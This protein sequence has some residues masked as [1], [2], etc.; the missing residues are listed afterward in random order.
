MS[1]LGQLLYQ[2]AIL[3][4]EDNDYEN[5][6]LGFISAYNEGESREEILQILYNCFITPNEK[7]FEKT[8]K[9]N[10]KKY[11][12]VS[13]EQL[14]LDF[15]PVAENIYYIFDKEERVFKGKIDCDREHICK[16]EEI[17]D[18]FNDYL[19]GDIW[20]L[21]EILPFSLAN[22]QQTSV[23]ISSDIRKTASFGKL[24]Q[25]SENYMNNIMIFTCQKEFELYYREKAE[26]YVPK[27]LIAEESVENLQKTLLDLHSYRISHM[28][29]N[30][31]NVFLSVCIPSLD[32]GQKALEAVSILL[33]SI[34]DAEIEVIVSNNGS[35]IN[36][37]GYKSIQK[38]K[39]SRL[40]YHEFSKNQ[41]FLG[42]I[43]KVLSMAR[44]RF[45]VLCSDEDRILLENLPYYLDVL[46][47]N[48]DIGMMTSRFWNYDSTWKNDDKEI[49]NYISVEEY[50][51]GGMFCAMT[52]NYITGTIYNTDI[53]RQEKILNKVW[54]CRENLFVQI[55]PHLF[56]NMLMTC[57]HD[58]V[59]SNIKLWHCGKSDDVIEEGYN[60][61]FHTTSVFD[62]ENNRI[63]QYKAQLDLIGSQMQLSVQ[64]LIGTYLEIS[65]NTL[66]L[67]NVSYVYFDN[68]YK[69]KGYSHESLL[70][71][72][73]DICLN[74]IMG[75]V[76][77]LIAQEGKD[78]I[79]N[80]MKE[81][82]QSYIDAVDTMVIA[83]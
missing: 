18:R 12:N 1:D 67:A 53:M 33:E 27:Q 4:F 43:C 15:I 20:D 31:N 79:V 49:I 57:R 74:E 32:R 82:C 51:L 80:I 68:F 7:E 48:P 26:L 70:T 25:F 13:Y 41:G 22:F 24:P 81:C 11:L 62:G 39:D 23:L 30:R 6:V 35:T 17:A 66:R 76:G 3:L 63:E 69:A 44:G 8:Y 55:Y 38:I 42:N 28:E 40:V 58:Y 71:S 50:G 77:Y 19:F 29:A 37:E 61:K 5:A 45:A 65:K 83:Q 56:M 47:S 16:Q 52:K 9:R 64:E 21:R 78:A 10:Q 75:R 73:R 2:K 60:A 54:D 36:R 46:R 72:V 59:I 34:Y 14:V